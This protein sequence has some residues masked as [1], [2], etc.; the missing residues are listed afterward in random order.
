MLSVR[1]L[2]GLFQGYV[3]LRIGTLVERKSTLKPRSMYFIVHHCSKRRNAKGRRRE[4][5]SN[6]KDKRL[7]KIKI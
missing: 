5:N 3:S 4:F 7:D 1:Q 2:F 6:K